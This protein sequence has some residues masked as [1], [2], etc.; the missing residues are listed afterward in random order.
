MLILKRVRHSGIDSRR[1]LA[2]LLMVASGFAGLGYQIVWTQQA[3]LWL[4]HESAAVLAVVAAFFGGLALGA[5]V[6]AAKIEHSR[7]PLIW[8]AACE[9]IIG[10][11]A[12][13]LVVLM[14]ILGHGLLQLIGT[15]PTAL[16]QWSVTFCGVFLV[17][18]P[19]TMAMGA[20]LPA[21]E[22][23]GAE[24]AGAGRSI[25][26]FY[27][28]N[29]A[30]A[31]LGVSLSTFWLVPYFGLRA[32]ATVCVALNLLCAAIALAGFPR[33]QSPVRKTMHSGILNVY[34]ALFRLAATGLL[35]IGYEVM[36]VRIISQVTENTIYSFAILL[37]VYLVGTAVGAAL[38]QHWREKVHD[39]RKITRLLFVAQATTCLAGTAVLWAAEAI[40]AAALA[41][42]GSGM[43]A[44]IGAE[45]LLALTAFGLPTL[46]M[47]AL[48]CHLSQVA[49]LRGAGFGLAL[50]VNTLAAALAPLLF[51]VL[52]VPAIGAKLTLVAIAL[53][54]LAVAGVI[55]VSA[56]LPVS[57]G[58]AL[59]VWAPPLMFVDVPEGGRLIDYREGQMATVSVVEDGDGIKTLRINN[60][61]QEGSSATLLVDGRQALLPMLLH[62]EP[63]RALFLGLGTGTTAAVAA[64]DP[65]IKVDAV[66][67][68]PEVIEASHHFV[69]EFTA[70]GLSRLNLLQADARR[71]I[72]LSGQKYDV[73][74][75]DNFHPARSG[76]GLLYTEEHFQAV[77][78]RLNAGG[79]FCQWL[80]LHQLSLDTLRSIVKSFLAV[81]PNAWL[82]LASNSLTTPVIGLIG[83]DNDNQRFDVPRLANLA[84]PMSASD[85]GIDDDFALFG[86][87][88]AGPDSLRRFSAPVPA[89]T[90]D[91]PVVVYRAPRITYEAD[92]LPSERMIELL[93]EV[94]L[95]PSELMVEATDAIWQHRIT[96][97]WQA[98]NLYLQAGRHVRPTTNAK[99]MLAQIRQP[100]L[101]VL[102]HSA[103]FR[104]A[105]DPLL[106]I[107]R[108][109]MATD[110][111]EAKSLLQEL[112]ILQPL[113]PEAFEL[114]RQIDEQ[115]SKG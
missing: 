45:A 4:G 56:A 84:L 62:A 51:G 36:V 114:L 78:E 57:I 58:L 104:P 99:F 63:R 26:G 38:Y 49:H 82:L 34:S 10:L 90:D 27:A 96:A 59:A 73:I 75:A 66:E 30:G 6:T 22:R 85:F 35:G 72:K 16:W 42:L 40:K 50:G 67:L 91:R 3:S 15:Q 13:L 18:L 33:R 47:G 101:A 44:A 19:A 109:L 95:K 80:P 97:Y 7:Q 12:L 25:A 28:A 83:R 89:N 52:L 115:T 14:P 88:V 105:Y 23:I 53:G 106:R 64:T 76:S 70:S 108:A 81:Y 31:V 11:W 98:R 39:N 41:W 55:D 77:R 43:S 24:F 74:V 71:Y 61:Q 29:T 54:Y 113:R 1:F 86:G 48:F 111:S 2:L 68:L 37:A 32:T 65:G 112:S 60:R 103:D 21:M 107:A 17:L 100:L 69:Q 93:R 8:Y 79:L 9:T 20:T 5:L 92:S 94:E 87:F 110:R 46:V 102:R